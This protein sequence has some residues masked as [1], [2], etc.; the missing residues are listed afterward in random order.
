MSWVAITIAYVVCAWVTSSAMGIWE[1]RDS[2]VR[3]TTPDMNVCWFGVVWPLAWFVGVVYVITQAQV[4]F[5]KRAAR[6][7]RIPVVVERNNKELER[8]LRIEEQGPRQLHQW[9]RR[10]GS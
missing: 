9:R 1:L 5:C 8:R 6:A 4:W 7:D 10:D 2:A 3:D